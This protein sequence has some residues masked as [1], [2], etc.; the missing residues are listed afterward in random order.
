[1]ISKYDTGSEARI[2][3]VQP[4]VGVPADEWGGRLVFKHMWI[5]PEAPDKSIYL[6]IGG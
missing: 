5:L 1:M 2:R 3:A 4:F 6:K